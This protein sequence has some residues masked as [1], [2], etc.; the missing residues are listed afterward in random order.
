MGKNSRAIS[1]DQL[2]TR[3]P[4]GQT[5][6][7]L[8]SSVPTDS[9]L[10][11]PVPPGFSEQVNEEQTQRDQNERDLADLN[12]CDDDPDCE[13]DSQRYLDLIGEGCSDDLDLL[14]RAAQQCDRADGSFDEHW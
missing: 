1:L 3:M 5:L 10:G 6:R 13:S 11:R 9:A 4:Q 7:E 12:D 8:L 14:E 2:A